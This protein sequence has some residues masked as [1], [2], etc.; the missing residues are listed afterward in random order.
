MNDARDTLSSQPQRQKLRGLGF[1]LIAMSGFFASMAYFRL[2]G[3][4]I[5]YQPSELVPASFLLLG[6][7]GLGYAFGGRRLGFRYLRLWAILGITAA[8]VGFI[9][10]MLL[11]H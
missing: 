2:F 5:Q 8:V 1:M 10:V 4:A 6:M 11:R 3:H 9:R 7:Y